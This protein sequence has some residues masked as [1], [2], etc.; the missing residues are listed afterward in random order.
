MA[1]N[2]SSDPCYLHKFQ[3]AKDVWN[4]KKARSF[5]KSAVVAYSQNGY[6]LQQRCQFMS[7]ATFEE[8]FKMRPGDANISTEVIEGKEGIVIPHDEPADLIVYHDVRFGVEKTVL[9]EDYREG[10]APEV[11]DWYRKRNDLK[12]FCSEADI[13]K[14][15]D[16]VM[17]Q[18]QMK[19]AQAKLQADLA[20]AHAVPTAEP[21]QK[22]DE[23]SSDGEDESRRVEATPFEVAAGPAKGRGKGASKLAGKKAGE[24]LRPPKVPKAQAGAASVR[25]S[26]VS[27]T[28]SV[29][30]ASKGPGSWKVKDDI[31]KFD[32]YKA[33]LVLMD[34]LQSPSEKTYGQLLHQ[35]RATLASWLQSKPTAPDTVTL[36]GMVETGQ[37]AVSLCADVIEKLSMEER[38]SVLEELQP[39][40][41]KWPP[42]L[43]CSLLQMRAKELK[44]QSPGFL[45]DV[46]QLLF[47]LIHQDGVEFQYTSPRL[48]A[49][50]LTDEQRGSLLQTIMNHI[51]IALVQGDEGGSSVTRCASAELL[52]EFQQQQEVATSWSLQAAVAD[53][54]T[55]CTAVSAALDPISDKSGI[56]ALD[57]LAGAQNG[58]K[59]LLHEAAWGLGRR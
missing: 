57:M 3:E 49:A 46:K 15:V 26:V 35:A 8:K 18:R 13:Q 37:K 2:C 32:R 33:G 50:D 44:L 6:K 48:C 22:T 28:A 52:K 11:L 10:Q 29:S 7:V 40:V 42:E 21:S 41:P 27:D 23:Q 17:Q 19:E 24:K 4:H 34:I 14:K 38:H 1:L 58:S 30:R 53:A 20:Q 56:E 5:F 55:M 43:Q 31:R 59:Y 45:D 54:I 12:Q 47:P 9:G 51:L 36:R 16:A 39:K 25:P